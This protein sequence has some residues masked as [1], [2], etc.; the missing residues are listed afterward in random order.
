VTEPHA[1]GV[2]VWQRMGA[3]VRHKPP[4][5]ALTMGRAVRVLTIAVRLAD[6][7]AGWA[8]L[9]RLHDWLTA[10]A[11]RAATAV[12]PAAGTVRAACSLARPTRPTR[13]KQA[14][15]RAVCGVDDVL[16]VAAAEDAQ[17]ECA[18]VIDGAGGLAYSVGSD[19]ARRAEWLSAEAD[20]ATP[21]T[22][23]PAAA[24]RPHELLL[25][26]LSVTEVL[27]GR[28]ALWAS[29]RAA[30]ALR[31]LQLSRALGLVAAHVD[32]SCMLPEAHACEGPEMLRAAAPSWLA[33]M[34]PDGDAAVAAGCRLCWRNA[35]LRKELGPGHVRATI[36]ALYAAGYDAGHLFLRHAEHAL[37]RAVTDVVLERWDAE[38]CSRPEEPPPKR[39]RRDDGPAPPGADAGGRDTAA[40][41]TSAPLLCGSPGAEAA[42]A[43]SVTE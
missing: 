17:Q 36:P 29:Q 40:A 18:R 32:A 39:A 30:G 25:H 31:S 4:H 43:A 9:H 13:V 23:R 19:G 33:A 27:T 6:P 37:A 41:A 10:H 35:N 12:M 34:D 21:L 7:V 5:L 15:R 26:G 24:K 14:I 28:R 16:V 38:D 22:M 3:D 2:V 8:L 1:S 11:T 20:E 42:G